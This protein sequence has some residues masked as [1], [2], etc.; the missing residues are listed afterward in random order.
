M[1]ENK[2]KQNTSKNKPKKMMVTKGT[3]EDLP[4]LTSKELKTFLGSDKKKEGN[5]ND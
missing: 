1:I 4:N 3:L 5:K 2:E